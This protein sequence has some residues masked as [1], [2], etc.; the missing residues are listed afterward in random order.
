M[1]QHSKDGGAYFEGLRHSIQVD[2]VNHVSEHRRS[3]RVPTV[4][5]FFGIIIRMYYDDHGPPHFHAY[6]GEFAAKIDIATL[7]VQVGQLPKR[8]LALVTE[9]AA[10]HRDELMDNWKRCEAHKKLNKIKPLE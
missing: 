8:A 1:S 9:W 10:Q 5:I 7:E 3:Y 6:Y 2:D 4:C